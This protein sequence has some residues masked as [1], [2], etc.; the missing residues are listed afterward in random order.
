MQ[1]CLNYLKKESRTTPALSSMHPQMHTP[2]SNYNIQHIKIKCK[3]YRKFFKICIRL[4][5]SSRI[6]LA[7]TSVLIT[8]L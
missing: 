2:I 3:N 7:A 1:N 5:K 6:T 4:V 8:F